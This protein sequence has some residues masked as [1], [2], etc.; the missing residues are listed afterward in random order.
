MF[1][2]NHGCV[3][4]LCAAA[5]KVVVKKE[6]QPKVPQEKKPSGG[7]TQKKPPASPR[8]KNLSGSPSKKGK[9]KKKHNPWSSSEEEFSEQSDGSAMDA[10]FEDMTPARDRGPRRAAGKPCGD[11]TAACSD[12]CAAGVSRR[13]RQPL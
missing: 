7:A 3:D 9:G 10:S 13:Q 5:S 6:Q 2:L 11:N 1:A 4:L 12:H 8:T